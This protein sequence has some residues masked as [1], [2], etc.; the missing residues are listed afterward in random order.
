MWRE[1]QARPVLFC[2]VLS[3]RR[4]GGR[5]RGRGATPSFLFALLFFWLG[6]KGRNRGRSVAPL[7]GMGSFRSTAAPASEPGNKKPRGQRWKEPPGEEPVR[8][9]RGRPMT[10]N[11]DLDP[12]PDPGDG[13]AQCGCGHGLWPQCSERKA[14]LVRG[15]VGSRSLD[16]GFS[17]DRPLRPTVPSCASFQTPHH[18]TPPRRL[19]RLPLRSGTSPTAASPLASSSSSSPTPSSGPQTARTHPKRGELLKGAFPSRKAPLQ[20]SS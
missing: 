11:L 5:N 3:F 13:E 20:V 17:S 15:A 6:G 14:K 18:P 10:K 9:K 16:S 8:K 7:R 19:L 2:S 4:G 12:D 1:A